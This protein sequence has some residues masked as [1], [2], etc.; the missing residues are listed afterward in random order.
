MIQAE[1]RRPLRPAERWY[2]IA[3]YAVLL[4]PGRLY[5]APRL[6]KEEGPQWVP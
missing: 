2:W 1:V 4:V 5:S 6:V 3:R